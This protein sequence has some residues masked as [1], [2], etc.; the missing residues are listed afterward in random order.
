MH[1]CTIKRYTDHQSRNYEKETYR[2]ATFFKLYRS[3]T[4]DFVR[5][6]NLRTLGTV[7]LG[8]MFH[9]NT[10]NEDHARCTRQILVKGKFIKTIQHIPQK[11]VAPKLPLVR[12]RQL[13]FS[14]YVFIPLISILHKVSTGLILKIK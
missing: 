3:F 13:T 4:Y 11:F 2:K 1:S 6:K 14:Y 7:L 8:L 10:N 9:C 12:A 5:T